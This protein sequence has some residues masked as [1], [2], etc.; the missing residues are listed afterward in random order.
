MAEE[1]CATLGPVK[2]IRTTSVHSFTC[3]LFSPTG[4]ENP[5]RGGAGRAPGSWWQS[6]KG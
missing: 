4:P 2:V 3:T 5:A 1:G 6:E